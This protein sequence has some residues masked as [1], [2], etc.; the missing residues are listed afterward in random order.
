[1]SEGVNLPIFKYLV[2]K[3]F[4]NFAFNLLQSHSPCL[5][6]H[7]YYFCAYSNYGKEIKTLFYEKDQIPDVFDNRLCAVMARKEFIHRTK[8]RSTGLDPG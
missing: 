4:I 2:A 8:P 3:K 7:K 5:S 6:S 1:M